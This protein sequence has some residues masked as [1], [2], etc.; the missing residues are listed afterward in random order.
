MAAGDGIECFGCRRQGGWGAGLL[1]AE[2]RL[3]AF[4]A[5]SDG[6]PRPISTRPAHDLGGRAP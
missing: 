2:G 4:A 3:V 5:K 6:K 1:A